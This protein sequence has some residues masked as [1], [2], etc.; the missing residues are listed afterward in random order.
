MLEFCVFTKVGQRLRSRL[1][2]HKFWYAWEGLVTSN[3]H[4]KYE[5]P[6]SQRFQKL[7]TK[8][9]FCHNL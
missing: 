5:S 8:L 3:T 7:W 2:V 1:P 6:I 4:V 9:K